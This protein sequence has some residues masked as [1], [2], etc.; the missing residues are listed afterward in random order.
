[1]RHHPTRDYPRHHHDWLCRITLLTPHARALAR[2]HTP[3]GRTSC[4]KLGRHPHIWLHQERSEPG[5][6]GHWFRRNGYAL[7]VRKPR[8]GSLPATL[9]HHCGAVIFGGPM[10]ANDTDEFIGR[11]TP[12]DRRRTQGAETTSRHLPWRADARQH[13]REHE[14]Q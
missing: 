3:Q 8:Y 4:G 6:V 1:T 13:L 11:E 10:S 2:S 9:A 7:D 5:H 12:L 14:P